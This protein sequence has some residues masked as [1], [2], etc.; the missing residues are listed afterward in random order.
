M[1]VEI[2][3][4]EDIARWDKEDCLEGVERDAIVKNLRSA[5]APSVS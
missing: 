2:Y 3:S 1:E 4:D 5:L